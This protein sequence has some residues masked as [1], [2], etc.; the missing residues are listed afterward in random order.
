MK[1][2]RSLERGNSTVGFHFVDEGGWKPDLNKIKIIPSERCYFKLK[3][4][5]GRSGVI[6]RYN[7][8][9]LFSLLLPEENYFRG[10]YGVLYLNIDDTQISG[11]AAEEL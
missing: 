3:L 7:S 6:T 9:E 2:K 4:S 5:N 11:Y 8:N 1:F 10:D